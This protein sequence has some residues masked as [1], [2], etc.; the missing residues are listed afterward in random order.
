MSTD[1]WWIDKEDVGY[2]YVFYIHTHNGILLSRRKEWNLSICD[3]SDE[4]RGDCTM[5]NKSKRERQ[6][7]SDYTYI[8]NLKNKTN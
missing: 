6:I 5:W 8:W 2:V 1:R 7:P 3:N 4:S